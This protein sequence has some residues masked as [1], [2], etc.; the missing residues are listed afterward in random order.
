MIS[1]FF[2]SNRSRGVDLADLTRLVRRYSV[3]QQQVPRDL[4][5]LV[6][7]NYLES[8]PPPPA[9]RKYIIDRKAVEVRLE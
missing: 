6:A 4:V 8:V 2:K 5:E 7:L 9:G 3:E 1:K